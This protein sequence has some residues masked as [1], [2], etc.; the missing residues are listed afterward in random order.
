MDKPRAYCFFCL[1]RE[2]LFEGFCEKRIG[3]LY[4]PVR[5]PR[6][7]NSWAQSPLPSPFP[8]QGYGDREPFHRIVPVRQNCLSRRQVPGMNKNPK[9]PAREWLNC[10]L[11]LP[12]FKPGK[13]MSLN[14]DV[15][16]KT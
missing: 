9:L 13:N 4:R 2:S 7:S 8:I 10:L 12:L 3:S 6:A 15:D 16:L 11:P 14:I 5:R 1:I